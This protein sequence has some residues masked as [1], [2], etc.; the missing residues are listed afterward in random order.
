[1][2]DCEHNPKYIAK[3]DKKTK[4]SK[5][6]VQSSKSNHVLLK[7]RTKF[8][9]KAAV[10]QAVWDENLEKAGLKHGGQEGNG[11]SGIDNSPRSNANANLG[12]VASPLTSPS[13][14]PFASPT[15]NRKEI[16][17]QE[18][19]S[20]TPVSSVGQVDA[21]PQLERPPLPILP[22]PM[23]FLTAGAAE[24][25]LFQFV[26]VMQE[27]ESRRRE[28]ESRRRE[29]EDRRRDKRD[30]ARDAQMQR[31]L[32]AFVSRGN[33]D[34][35]NMTGAK[36][37]AESKFKDSQRQQRLKE[38]AEQEQALVNNARKLVN[39][40]E[41]HFPPPHPPH[42]VAKG[43]GTGQSSVINLVEDEEDD[44][45]EDD[46]MNPAFVKEEPEKRKG[47]RIVPMTLF[48]KAKGTK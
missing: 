21:Q 31:L 34:T 45:Y 9:V 2:P 18:R 24:N 6:G 10:G 44:D 48:K 37:K 4:V 26:V 42:L 19:E 1:M 32:E 3:E 39:Q 36:A 23:S 7:K 27:L 5:Q 8:T 17:E 35:R 11:E 29:E 22:S 25:P 40:S 33:Q 14:S 46:P 20:Q 12:P 13:A 30:A 28:E 41:R 43:T 15:S 47:E 16:R 38:R